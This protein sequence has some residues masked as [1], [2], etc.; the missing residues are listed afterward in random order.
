MDPPT[1]ATLPLYGS[2]DFAALVGIECTSLTQDFPTRSPQRNDGE[3][4]NDSDDKNTSDDVAGRDL[5]TGPSAF[6]NPSF[7]PSSILNDLSSLDAFNMTDL[8]LNPFTSMLRVPSSVAEDWARVYYVV[9]STLIEACDL[10]VSDPSRR[11]HI[12]RAAKWY[13]GL[14][15]LFLRQPGRS[16]EKNV[17]I[18][19]LR[20][21]QFLTGNYSDLVSH[22]YKDV[23]KQRARSR[24]HRAESSEQRV[25]RASD[26]ILSGEI[27]RGLRIID[28][29]GCAPHDDVRVQEQMKQKHP[30]PNPTA[31]WPELPDGWA[32]CAVE[33]ISEDFVE[34]LKSAVRKADFRKGVGPRRANVHHV[35]V[36]ADGVFDHPEA[37]K[38]FAVFAKLGLKYLFLGMPAWLRACLGGGLLTALNKLPPVTGGSIEARPIKAEDSDTNLWAKALA[39]LLASSVLDVVRPQQLGVGV[40][41]GVELYVSGFK[42]KFEEACATGTKKVIVK[43]D[44]KNAHNSF[45]RDKTQLKL[46]ELARERPGL[47]PLAVAHESIL[48]APNGI[49]MCSNTDPSG[50][51]L[52]C[53]SLMGGGQGNPLTGQLYVVNQD[54]ALKFVEI[55][56]PSVEVKAIQDDVTIMGSPEDVFDVVDDQGS[57][58]SKGALTVLIEQLEAR[59]LSMAEDKFECAG[60]TVDACAGKPCWLKESTAFTVG[61]G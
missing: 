23:V 26:L 15:Q 8:C 46:I 58:V 1:A 24:S 36:L 40:S 49:Y 50:F 9:T 13:C 19:K 28:S 45:P 31:V 60:S 51:I 37:Q 22:W 32:A 3:F 39:K 48:R 10:P 52:L 7:V 25:K 47:I 33:S 34:V 6:D 5:P 56:F 44:V 4:E 54:S 30:T 17:N 11:E 12:L 53:Q 35:Q 29:N 2:T 61:D 57:V 42:L 14:P 21:H 16:A 59:G 38:A 18:I 41:G 43:T 27:G 20:L 55:N